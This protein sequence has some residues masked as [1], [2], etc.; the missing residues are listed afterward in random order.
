MPSLAGEPVG[1]K[2][3]LCQKHG[4]WVLS[5]AYTYGMWYI[6]KVLGPGIRAVV[7]SLPVIRVF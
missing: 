3:A 1:Q 4:P 2:Q 6:G 5:F 7:L